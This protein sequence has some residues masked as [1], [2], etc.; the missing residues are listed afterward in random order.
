MHKKRFIFLSFI[1]FSLFHINAQTVSGSI[2]NHQNKKLYLYGYENFDSYPID[3][4]TTN[5]NGE[6]NLKF[7]P[8]DFGMGYITTKN[9]KSLIVVLANENIELTADVSDL[10]QTV[11]ITSGPEN[12]AFYTYTIEQPKRENALSAWKYLDNLYTKDETFNNNVKQ[13]QF[14]SRE[15]KR[16]KTESK[17]FINDLPEESYIKWF[18]PKR[19]L[20]SS[21]GT[22]VKNRPEEI[23]ATLKA[24]REMDLTDNRFY[25]SGLLNDAL[26]NHIWFIEN[27]SGSLEEVFKDLNETIDI[28]IEQLKDDNEKFNLVTE[29]IFEILEK[30][31]LYTSSEYLADR[32]LKSD[33]CGCLNPDFEK[34]LNIYGK[35][36]QGE[37][38]PDIA[39]TKF[40]Y[41]PKGVNA[42]YLSGLES[43]YYL[44]VFAAGW[45]PHCTQEV[46][47]IADLYPELK[48]K[49]I[50]VI[51]VSLDE[52]AQDFTQFAA[53]FPFI[54]TTDYQKWDGKTVNDYQVIGTPSYFMLDKDRKILK[55]LKS[56]DHLKSWV[57]Y[58]VKD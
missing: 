52:N 16:L 36:A 30:R 25:K 41:F 42:K 27:S 28:I 43:D 23:S 40:T 21:L 46:P 22:I 18:L 38:A 26:F 56:I 5:A 11:N 49:N 6:F 19:Y 29:R 1:I 54:S 8:K 12:K 34:H 58:Y 37:I 14:I 17:D 20:L 53:P 4:I 57:E 51:L 31:S 50:E 15:I 55:K 24:L 47:E 48:A 3:S 44:V 7:E 10:S 2:A 32:L 39:F 13:S 33:D 9:N 45:C 35:M